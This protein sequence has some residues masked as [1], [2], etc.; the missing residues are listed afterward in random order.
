M[1]TATH[2]CSSKLKPTPALC[3]LENYLKHPKK[4]YFSYI[5]MYIYI[6][7]YVYIYI[8]IQNGMIFTFR[9]TKWHETHLA[10][11]AKKHKKV[12]KKL[13]RKYYTNNL[14]I[15]DTVQVCNSSIL[16]ITHYF[17]GNWSWN[18]RIGVWKKA[19]FDTPLQSE[20]NIQICSLY[21]Q[22]KYKF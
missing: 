2:W 1:Y 21:V 9:C 3:F 12:W 7:I 19:W 5:Y 17:F 4:S 16:Y 20:Q 10:T 11:C 18:F 6:Y 13:E 8:Y 14:Y 15:T 22:T